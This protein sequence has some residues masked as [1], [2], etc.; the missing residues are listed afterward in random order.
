LLQDTA[1]FDEAAYLQALENVAVYVARGRIDFP[2]LTERC[3]N[4]L[5]A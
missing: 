4:G 1:G 3:L 2:A 5:L